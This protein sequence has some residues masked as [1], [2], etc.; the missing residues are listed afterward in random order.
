[1]F[2]KKFNFLQHVYE[3]YCGALNNGHGVALIFSELKDIT[4]NV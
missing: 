4:E 2:F 3:R 1:M